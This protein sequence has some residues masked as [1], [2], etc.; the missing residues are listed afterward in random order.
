MDLLSLYS[1]FTKNEEYRE[2]LLQANWFSSIA[3]L[4]PSTGDSLPLPLSELL[5]RISDKKPSPF[6]Q[7]RLWQLWQHSL[8]S[9]QRITRSLSE[10]PRRMSAYLPLREVRELDTASFIALSRRPGRNVREK[11]ADRPYMQ[12]VRH[13]QSLDTLE[14]RLLKDYLVKLAD[15][16]ELRVR[17][18]K[19]KSA[20]ETLQEIFRWL[21]TEEATSISPLRAFTP[22][23]ALL[24]HRDYKKVLESWRR[25]LSLEE[26]IEQDYSKLIDRRATKKYWES[27]AKRYG[28]GSEMFAEMPVLMDINSFK[29]E[30]WVKDIPTKKQYINR[31]KAQCLSEDG[32]VCVDLVRLR[33]AYAT[34]SKV[35]VLDDRFIW[36]KWS[37]EGET[38]EISLFDSDAAYVHSDAST[39][40]SSDMFFYKGRALNALNK[41]ARSFSARL[42]E[43]FS[44]RG[45]VWVVPDELNE[46]ELEIL[47]RNLNLVFPDSEPLPYSIASVVKNI[48]YSAIPK[49]GY[50][51]AVV[52]RFNGS[53]TLTE[54]IARFDQDL[55]DQVPETHGYIWEKGPT[56]PLSDKVDMDEVDTGVWFLGSDGEFWSDKINPYGTYCSSDSDLLMD[57]E[58]Y[59]CALWVNAQPVSGG[60]KLHSLQAKTNDIPLWRNHIPELMT[61]VVMNGVYQPFYFVGRNT[62]VQP[63]RGVPSKIKIDKEF[64]LPKGKID[65]RLPLHQGSKET[66]LEYEA[67]LISPDFPYQE[68]VKCRLSMTYTYGADEPYSLTFIP[69]NQAYKPI[70][71]LWHPK[72]E[73]EITDAPGPAYPTPETWSDLRH[74][75]NPRKNEYNDLVEWA[76]NSSRRLLSTLNPLFTPPLSGKMKTDWRESKKEGSPDFSFIVS[77]DGKEYYFNTFSLVRRDKKSELSKGVLVRFYLDNSGNRDKA[78]YVDINDENASYELSQNIKTD[79]NRI[80]FKSMQFPFL[81]IWKDG[82]SFESAGSEDRF[83]TLLRTNMQEVASIVVKPEI[84]E[85]LRIDLCFLL[86]CMGSDMPDE[87]ISVIEDLTYRKILPERSLALALGNLSTPWQKSLLDHVLNLNNGYALRVLSHAI[88]RS[89]DF[90]YRIPADRLS[91]VLDMLS[92]KLKSNRKKLD[93]GTGSCSRERQFDVIHFTKYLELLLG[94]LRLRDSDDQALQMMLQPGQQMTKDFARIVESTTLSASKNKD[95]YFSRIQLDVSMRSED[96]KTPDILFA[97]RLYLEGDNAANTI[98][99]TGISE[100]E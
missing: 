17:F 75:F 9:V 78:I 4:D 25:L 59:D 30:P 6:L 40:T 94:L 50:K 81:S 43:H 26:D 74:H 63:K 49:D 20:E 33:P 51:V 2:L 72:E 57:L 41:A 76:A 32:I 35:G 68:D 84:D 1:S 55:S 65:Y 88:W 95:D 82:N 93:S 62:T 36:Q 73:V 15:A 87:V 8:Q 12:A 34:S 18:L 77:D 60:I 80:I 7:D 24:S 66:S 46:F 47:R 64:V 98:R 56:E 96:D 5:R 44:S 45:I 53:A 69:V 79:A 97:L 85:K 22:N 99:V 86:C 28:G 37:R 19:D 54:V 100:D 31:A 90:V 70:K 11:L 83:L 91:D 42:G 52:E 27:V 48:D 14:N 10:E 61:K 92:S 89:E 29:I 13:Y 38:V 39:V 16:L 21:N 23:N 3:E 58:G 67:K 71:V